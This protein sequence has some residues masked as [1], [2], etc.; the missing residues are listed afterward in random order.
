MVCHSMAT[1]FLNFDANAGARLL[2][3][4]RDA[5]ISV[6]DHAANPSSIHAAGR[7]SRNM[8][9]KARERV[10][11]A[12]GAARKDQLVFTSGATEAAALALSPNIR[13]G[14]ETLAV[15]GL[16]VAAT[17]HPCVLSGGRLAKRLHI[18]PVLASGIVDLAA[19][20]QM[21]EDHD[22]AAGVP[23]LALMLA[24]N[25]TGVL[26]PVVD[27]VSLI[28]RHGGF[29]FCDAVQAFGRI[30]V[31]IAALGADFIS[32]SSHKIGGPQGAGAMVMASEDVRPEP[33]LAGGGQERG[34]RAGT[35]NVAAIVGFGIA[36][37][38]VM[39]HLEGTESIARLR[40]GLE[41][42]LRR[43]SPDIRIAGDSAPRLSNTA[44][45]TVPGLSAETAVIA[46]DLEGIEVSSGSAC[47]SGKVAASHVLQAMGFSEEMAGSGIRI[48]LPVDVT[49]A[50]IETFLM[51]WRSIE[52]RLRP[53]QAA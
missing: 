33:F 30:A 44:M 48:S 15:G 35:E 23:M 53:N 34:F 5:V 6:L 52:S 29:V 38:A 7:Q 16:Y 43:I 8:V 2:P 41:T 13:K 27:A 28:R 21:L 50:D 1:G 12:C 31:D 46:L 39:N 14:R 51:V 25:E 47:S 4:A 17:E 37:E 3:A 9:E 42:E 45:F 24:N 10:A 19:L 26:Q 40:D 11:V 22:H 20:A 18:V 49:A 36:A 32:L